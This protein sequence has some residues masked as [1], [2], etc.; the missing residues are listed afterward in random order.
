MPKRKQDKTNRGTVSGVISRI[1][2]Q[3]AT[4]HSVS[5]E[6]KGRREIVIRGCKKICRYTPQIISLKLNYGTINVSGSNL[7]CFAFS[8]A[9]IGIF[10]NI[11][12]VFFTDGNQKGGERS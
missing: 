6:L 8:E 11:K 1:C 5:A 2:G 9:N 4:D 7:T 3:I 12:C 10:G